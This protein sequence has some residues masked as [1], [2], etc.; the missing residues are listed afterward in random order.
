[1]S[2]VSVIFSSH[3]RPGR[4]VAP[5]E[6]SFNQAKG[7]SGKRAQK[8]GPSGSRSGRPEGRANNSYRDRENRAEP[9]HEVA[10]SRPAVRN[11]EA[12]AGRAF[13]RHR[14]EKSKR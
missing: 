7:R 4:L 6:A 12:N 1:L 13:H 11:K 3:R 5:G 8:P 10:F 14:S 2:A 9:H